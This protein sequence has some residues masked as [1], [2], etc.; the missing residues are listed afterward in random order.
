MSGPTVLAP[1]GG[2]KMAAERTAYASLLSPNEVGG[3]V[4]LS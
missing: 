2:G 1:S 4:R 3:A